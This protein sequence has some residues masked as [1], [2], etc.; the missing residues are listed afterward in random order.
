MVTGWLKDG[1]NWYYLELNG[2]MAANKW[3]DGGRYYV[4]VDGRW[5]A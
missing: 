2:K 3:V 1:G 5:V 4:D